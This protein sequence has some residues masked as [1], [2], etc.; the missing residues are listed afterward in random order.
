MY[1]I[2]LHRLLNKC[3]R[4][5]TCY[6]DFFLLWARE[7]RKKWRWKWSDRPGWWFLSNL[8][9]MKQ[10]IHCKLW[11]KRCLLS[12]PDCLLQVRGIKCKMGGYLN[13]RMH[14]SC[15]SWLLLTVQNLL[16]IIGKFFFW[17]EKFHKSHDIRT[18]KHIFS[19]IYYKITVNNKEIQKNSHSFS[20]VSWQDKGSSISSSLSSTPSSS[21]LPTSLHASDSQQH[22]C[23]PADLVGS[24]TTFH[25]KHT[26]WTI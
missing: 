26:T 13:K 8:I 24:L 2:C 11:R 14:M 4:L 6:Q 23:H 19:T 12:S 15:M 18:T 22:R 21:S 17:V 7:W 10:C 5:V 3:W 1:S 20:E 16:K 25:N 9:H